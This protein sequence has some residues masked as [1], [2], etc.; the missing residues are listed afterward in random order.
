MKNQD[1]I[2]RTGFTLFSVISSFAF[3]FFAVSVITGDGATQ[4]MNAL[5]YVAGGYGLANI[6]ILSWAWR[7]QAAWPLLANKFFA[8]CFLGV[9]V[10]DTLSQGI[11]NLNQILVVLGLAGV[12]WV[13]WFALKNLCQREAA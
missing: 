2:L 12:L 13:N 4:W 8:L 11:E 7:N 10:V 9:L 5:A 6:Y 1:V 3:V